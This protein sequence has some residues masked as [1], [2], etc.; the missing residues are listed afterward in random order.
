MYSFI[1]F[2]VENE[3]RNAKSFC[4]A[5]GGFLQGWNISETIIANFVICILGVR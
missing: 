2:I 1:H 4:T 3:T 5:W